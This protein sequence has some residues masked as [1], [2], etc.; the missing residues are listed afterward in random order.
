MISRHESRGKGKTEN[1]LTMG[2]NGLR[3]RLSTAERRE[4][5][6]RKFG[7][8]AKESRILLILFVSLSPRAILSFRFNVFD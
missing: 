5:K 3:K 2:R 8:L 1:L 4:K 6:F 7:F